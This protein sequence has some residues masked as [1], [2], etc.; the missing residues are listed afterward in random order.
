MGISDATTIRR[1]GGVVMC[2][3]ITITNL[4]KV[5]NLKKLVE[6][7]AE[8]VGE[9]EKDGFGYAIQTKD[10]LFGERTISPRGFKYSMDRPEFGAPYAVSGYNRF[11]VKGKATGAG[12]FHGRTS[13]NQ[14]GVLNTHPI[15]KHGW[16][17]IHNGVVTNHGPKYPMV[18]GNDTEHIVELM[19]TI[20][21]TGVEE[22]LTGY[23]AFA[24]FDPA[25]RLHVVRDSTAQLHVAYIKEIEAVIFA[26]K[27]AHIDDLC[28][29]MKWTA[30]VASKV[31]ENVH[32]TFERGNAIKATH[33]SI[34][35]RGRTATES[36][37]ASK[38]LGYELADSDGAYGVADDWS[39]DELQFLQEMDMQADDTYSIL[40]F[41]GNKITIAEFKSL[42]TDWKLA[43]TVVRPDGT[44]CDQNDYASDK[45]YYGGVS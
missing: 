30:S 35:P 38:S 37:W 16:T 15:Q 32:L 2:K 7:A 26:T 14:A 42:E 6:V 45:L 13:T 10:G 23:Y 36:A 27:E 20:G 40:D 1:R 18:T 31:R 25:G 19:G 33:A 3:I 44:I 12:I 11:G 5:K 43:C 39:D 29:E 21:I 22:F 8:L 9:T 41:K 24:A 17:L 34:E 4:S 28:E